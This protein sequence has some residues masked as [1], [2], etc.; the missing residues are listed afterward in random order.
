MRTSVIEK[1]KHDLGDVVVSE[2]HLPDKGIRFYTVE[3]RASKKA[4]KSNPKL[5]L[6]LSVTENSVANAKASLEKFLE[7]VLK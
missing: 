3:F 5:P 7:R 4:L 1:I 2:E 6:L